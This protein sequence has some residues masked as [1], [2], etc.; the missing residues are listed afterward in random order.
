[1]EYRLEKKEGGR[2]TYKEKRNEGERGHGTLKG[3]RR[4]ERKEQADGVISL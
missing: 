3:R 4:R 1:M 2:D